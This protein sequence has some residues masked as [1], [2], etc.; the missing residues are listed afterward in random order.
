LRAS[1]TIMGLR[2]PR[3]FSVR[4]RNHR[5]NRRPIASSLAAFGRQ[6]RCRSQRPRWG[7]LDAIVPG[8][9]FR[10]QRAARKIR[11]SSL[12]QKRKT[13]AVAFVENQ[14][15]GIKGHFAGASC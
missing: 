5:A 3:S 10:I 8:L 2:V 12:L 15:A 9:S 7:R 13:E 11:V 4:A 1:A 14:S 6:P